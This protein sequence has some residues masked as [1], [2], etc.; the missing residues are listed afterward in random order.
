MPGGHGLTY[1][2]ALSPDSIWAVSFTDVAHWNG[3]TWSRT[4]V[5][6]LL[7]GCPREPDLCGPGLTG[8]YAQSPDSVWAIGTGHRETIGGPVV[9]L[10]FNGH[11]WSRVALNDTARDPVPGQVIPDGAGGLWIPT[12]GFEGRA[13]S[14]MLHYS[15]GHLGFAA[16]PAT[17]GGVLYVNA[18]AAV[19]GTRRAIGAG[20]TYPT[21]ASAHQTA[22]ILAYGR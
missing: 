8:I 10:H 13:P 11:H 5:K 9:V 17:Q 2:S 6:G 16:L 7:A 19:P 21:S 15:G 3:H 22:V 20:V 1:G 12:Y 14:M 4:S 18:V